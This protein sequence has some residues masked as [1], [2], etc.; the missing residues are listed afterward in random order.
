M[1]I[2][3]NVDYGLSD[4]TIGY[5]VKIPIYNYAHYVQLK[6]PRNLVMLCFA[7]LKNAVFEVH[8]LYLCYNKTSEKQKRS[9]LHL[10]QASAAL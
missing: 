8:T 9:V 6:F 4:I 3:L 10:H 2:N 7:M 5:K 1:F